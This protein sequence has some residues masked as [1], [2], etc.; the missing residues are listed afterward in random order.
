MFHVVFHKKTGSKNELQ[1]KNNNIF[2]KLKFLL[3]NTSF[4]YPNF[5]SNKL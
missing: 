4:L 3:I 5:Y 2:Y 1:V